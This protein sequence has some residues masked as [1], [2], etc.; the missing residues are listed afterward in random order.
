MANDLFLPITKT[1]KTT[2]NT[3]V[4]LQKL[5]LKTAANGTS[6]KLEIVLAPLDESGAWVSD[7][8]SVSI[9]RED[10]L[11][12][13]DPAKKYAAS[14]FHALILNA[15]INL[16]DAATANFA[17]MLR[18]TGQTVTGAETVKEFAKMIIPIALAQDAMEVQ[19]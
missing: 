2:E 10:S 1:V 18:A 11:F 5:T 19:S 7:A 17:A 9:Q 6:G 3:G 12:E 14:S 8:D 16:E 15:K 4:T 13:S